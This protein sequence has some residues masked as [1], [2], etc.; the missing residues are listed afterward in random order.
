MVDEHYVNPELAELYDLDSGW[1]VDSDFYLELAGHQPKDILDIGC[2]TGLLACAYASRGH[3]VTAVDPAEAM[4]NVARRKLAAGK[5]TWVQASAETFRS[6]SQFDLIVMTGNAMMALLE[7]EAM[8]ACLNT[9][10]HHLRD[11]GR[12]VFEV[13]N[14][15]L[16]WTSEWNYAMALKHDDMDV[17]ETRRF[18]AM[19][20]PLMRFEFDYVFPDKV[21]TTKS[22]IRFNS[23]SEIN[24]RLATAGLEAEDVRGGW[25]GEAF[26]PDISRYMIFTV[27]HRQGRDV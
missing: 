24:E 18:I 8:L 6:E 17:K 3:R 5:V 14:P 27:R 16:D 23:R 10:K 20:G 7:P 21:I 12:I 1:S 22:T 4:L 2:G 26:D 15:S 25:H 19:D 11:V 9:M 13:R